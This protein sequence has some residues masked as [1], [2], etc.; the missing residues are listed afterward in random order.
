MKT[1]GWSSEE[2][3]FLVF[4]DVVAADCCSKT[5]KATILSGHCVTVH[6]DEERQHL[7]KADLEDKIGG[8]GD[9]IGTSEAA[10]SH[11]QAVDGDARGLAHKPSSSRRYLVAMT[12]LN[13]KK[14]CWGFLWG[15]PPLPHASSEQMHKHKANPPSPPRL[16]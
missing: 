9:L 5:T 1:P 2:H 12:M 6:V 15:L 13:R 8:F 14:V 11:Q 10:K 16:N 7:A 3:G 4:T